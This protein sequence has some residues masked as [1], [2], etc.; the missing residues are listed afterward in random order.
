MAKRHIKRYSTS[1]IITEIKTTM[2]HLTLVRMA[3]IKSLQVINAEG[4]MEKRERSYT[5][6][7]K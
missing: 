1:L 4:G 3:I 7:G 5:V 6:A 2:N